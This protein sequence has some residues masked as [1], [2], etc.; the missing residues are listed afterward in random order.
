MAK[1]PI[2]ISNGGIA[3]ELAKDLRPADPN[4]PRKEAYKIILDNVEKMND[5]VSGKNSGNLPLPVAM[6]L[7][8]QH[9]PARIY[10]RLS[11]EPEHP[12]N[13]ETGA[14]AR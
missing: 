9:G 8:E 5:L 11:N 14:G 10:W 2:I 7:S 6:S 3:E 4:D 12:G 13:V 1:P